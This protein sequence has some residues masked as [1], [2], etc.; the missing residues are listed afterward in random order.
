VRDVAKIRRVRKERVEFLGSGSTTLNLAL[1]GKGKKGGWARGRIVN[2]VGDGSSGKTLLALELAFWC[3]KF[4]R[5]TQSSIFPKVRKVIIIYNNCEGV[6]DFPIEQMYGKEFVESVEWVCIKTIE[7]MGRDYLRRINALTKGTFLLYFID[8]WDA[9][10]SMASSKRMDESVESDKEPKGSYALEKQKYASSFFSNLAGKMESNKVD[11]TLIIISQVRTKIG[12]T[13]GKK[14]YRAGGKALD[15]Y[16]HQAAWLREVEKLRKTKRGK[17]RVYGIRCEAKV[18]RSKV[19]I[20][21]RE[22]E[23]TIL[24][25]YG[26]D[27]VNSMADFLWGKKQIHFDGKIF[28]TRQSFVKYV[29]KN[30][31]E[32]QL[33]RMSEREWGRVEDAFAADTKERKRRY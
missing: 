31:K 20:P 32:D 1:S 3:W 15:F 18:E 21:F 25:N 5:K 9:L 14:V 8:S 23:F 11:A 7:H 29:E 12:V 17:K 13:F 22:S 26:L 19:A 2:I 27:D 16:V 33:I 10:E 4:I 30:N 24:F 28:K 6:M